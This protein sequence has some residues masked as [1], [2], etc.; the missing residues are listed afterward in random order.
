MP[1]VK[2]R[3][4]LARLQ[5]ADAFHVSLLKQLIGDGYA[6]L[7]LYNLRRQNRV[8]RLMRGWYSFKKSPYL[9]WIPLR[10][11]VGLGHAA[12]F[13]GLWDQACII[14]I[15]TPRHVREGDRWV[16]EERVL[17]KRI[18]PSLLFGLTTVYIDDV[19]VRISDPEKTLVDLVFFNYPC[20]DEILSRAE[21]VIDR[22]RLQQHLAELQKK[23]PYRFRRVMKKLQPL[24]K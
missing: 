9:L 10:G 18:P 4:L 15:L 24:R 17:V 12:T 3:E 2:Y 23:K 11:Y 22:T 6:R 21:E 5:H 13:W 7:L 14:T 1:R 20:L 19:P 8:L 16:G